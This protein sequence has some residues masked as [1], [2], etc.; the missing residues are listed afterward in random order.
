M[1][2]NEKDA[3]VFP[4]MLRFSHIVGDGLALTNFFLRSLSNNFHEL[5]IDFER[6]TRS[7]KINSNNK[8]ASCYWIKLKSLLTTISNNIDS[9][10]MAPAIILY[11]TYLRKEDS[12]AL[13]N[14]RLSGDKI[15]VS[16]M[17][18]EKR[19]LPLVKKIKNSMPSATFSDVVLTGISG[20]LNK[21][22][23]NTSSFA[24]NFAT[25]V[26]TRLLSPPN[27]NERPI[28]QN[29]FSVALLDLPV[30]VKSN[31]MVDRLGAVMKHTYKLRKSHDWQG[32]AC[33]ASEK[34]VQMEQPFNLKFLVKLGK[35][36]I[37][38]Y[39][40]LK[41]VYGNECL[42]RTQVFEWFKRFNEGRETTEDD[43]R[44]GRP[45]KSK[46]DENIE[47]IGKLI[48]E[49]HR[50]STPSIRG[51]AEITGIDKECV[52]Q[53]LHE[54]FN[55]SKVGAKMV[56]K[57]FTSEQK[58]SRMNIC[59]DILN[60]ID[61]D[62][63]LLHTV[64]TCDES[65][66][67]VKAKATEVNY[68]LLNWFSGVI[69]HPVLRAVMNSNKA[70]M[71][72]SSV[73]GPQKLSILDGCDI[74]NIFFYTPHRGTTGVGFSILT[75]DD[76]FQIGLIVDKAIISSTD[77]AQLIVH[78]IFKDINLLAEELLSTCAPPQN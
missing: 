47:K 61:T 31:S 34:S 72:I 60:I 69:P 49:D 57:L 14:C 50:L 38:A 16:A 23:E 75:Y 52:R 56:S 5:N 73:P 29:Q 4:V 76:R 35:T 41:E 78:D 33:D 68:W 8:N 13:H 24:P 9:I 44:P 65:V 43:P 32:F 46:T 25:A 37:E 58:I 3:S 28:L 11:E 53:I 12:N 77:K 62:P 6:A 51:L 7:N 27:M 10:L 18:G 39:V 42:S 54:S 2:Q 20:S 74:E 70:T 63:N 64:I 1:K 21:Y 55:M 36:C 17:E 40:V 71:S 66:E 26:L 67:A 48:R 45:S 15:L 19:L 59:A 30:L 22:F